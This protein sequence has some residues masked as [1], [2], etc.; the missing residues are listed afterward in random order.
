MCVCVCVCVFHSVY[1]DLALICRF[2]DSVVGR[3]Q[4][5]DP[6]RKVETGSHD[7]GIGVGRSSVW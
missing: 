2:G 4:I 5:V 1:E 3:G 7:Q 6:L